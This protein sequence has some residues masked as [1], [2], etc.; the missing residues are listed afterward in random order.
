MSDRS[1]PTNSLI[2]SYRLELSDIACHPGADAWNAKVV[3]DDDIGEAL[4]YL[5]SELKG[6]DYHHDRKT[7]I[8]KTGRRKYAFRPHEIAMAPVEDIEEARRLME[9]VLGMVEAVWKRRADIKPTFCR[10]R[11]PGLIDIYGVLPRTNCR[12]CGC[13]SCMAF[14]AQLREGKA[15]WSQ[16]PSLSGDPCAAMSN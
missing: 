1:E 3:L 11:L 6:A 12:Q 13:P 14:A 4:P 9:E 8:W 16:C 7:L 5:N 10:R 15:E 2:H